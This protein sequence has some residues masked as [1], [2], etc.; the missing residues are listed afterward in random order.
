MPAPH[1]QL[2]DVPAPNPTSQDDGEFSHPSNPNWKLHVPRF[3]VR[4][5]QVRVGHVGRPA[6]TSYRWPLIQAGNDSCTCGR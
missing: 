1:V 5:G 6:L 2:A 3:D 4:P